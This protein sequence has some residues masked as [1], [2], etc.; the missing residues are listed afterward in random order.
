MG[1]GPSC[2]D[3]L[4]GARA[5]TLGAFVVFLMGLGLLDIV[6]EVLVEGL[7]LAGHF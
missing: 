4:L 6:S 2:E 1:A 7:I 3:S 5:L